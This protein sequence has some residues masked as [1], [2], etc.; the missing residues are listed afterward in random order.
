MTLAWNF[1][2]HRTRSDANT[3]WSFAQLGLNGFRF[4]R[5]PT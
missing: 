1:R 3:V 2:G 5:E 4:L